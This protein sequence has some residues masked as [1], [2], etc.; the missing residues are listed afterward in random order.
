[1]VENFVLS[2]EEEAVKKLFDERDVTRKFRALYSSWRSL[3]K[4]AWLA[5]L[6]SLTGHLDGNSI[7]I[8]MPLQSWT[9]VEKEK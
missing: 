2:N 6:L 4:E 1:M 5:L 9:S 8:V 7:F 3:A